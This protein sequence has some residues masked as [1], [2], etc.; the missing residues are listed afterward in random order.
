MAERVLCLH[1][2]ALTRILLHSKSFTPLHF[3]GSWLVLGVIALAVFMASWSL[4]W[5]IPLV[6]YGFA[7]VGHFFFEKNRPATFKHPL[8]SLMGD[9]V[10]FKDI[11]VGKIS[12]KGE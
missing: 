8:Y 4:L 7:W 12:L 1:K 10:M 2:Q 9:W 5:F 11:L 6:G 3:I